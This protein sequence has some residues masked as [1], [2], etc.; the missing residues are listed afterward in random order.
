M[1]VTRSL[2]ESE[3]AMSDGTPISEQSE[4][5]LGG[6]TS[7]LVRQRNDHRQ[8]DELLQELEGTSGDAQDAVLSRLARLVFPHAYAEETVLWPAIRAALP[9]GHAITLRVEQ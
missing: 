9:D 4:A 2:R 5:Q 7:V 6:S 1:P 3:S 8:L